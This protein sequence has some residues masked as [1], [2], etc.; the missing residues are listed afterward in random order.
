MGIV[1]SAKYMYYLRDPDGWDADKQTRRYRPSAGNT[2]RD[3]RLTF[4]GTFTYFVL[5]VFWRR[6]LI[7][8]ARQQHGRRNTTDRLG[9]Q[10]YT[11]PNA[12]FT[13]NAYIYLYERRPHSFLAR[14]TFYWI[15]PTPETIIV[16]FP[17]FF[18]FLK[19]SS[20]GPLFGL[21]SFQNFIW[22]KLA[23]N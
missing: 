18:F 8:F 23:F 14:S 22:C 11:T 5:C 19:H 2:S 20:F 3:F 21:A 4:R 15:E 7:V 13:L 1:C 12:M 10:R 16:L 17:P 9:S 6:R